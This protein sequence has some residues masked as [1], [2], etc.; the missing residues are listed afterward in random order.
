V[1]ELTDRLTVYGADITGAL[2]RFVGDEELYGECLAL[3]LEDPSF[4]A[5]DRAL[6][7]GNFS[8][9]FDAAHTLKGVAGNLGLTP[10]YRAISALV[11]PLRSRDGSR[12]DARYQSV[13]EARADVER[14]WRG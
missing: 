14:L 10:M 3:F 5:L 11:E 6:S 8:A 4:A 1:S 12:L 9:A 13:M 7:A 2:E